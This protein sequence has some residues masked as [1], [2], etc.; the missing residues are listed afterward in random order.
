MLLIKELID[1][2]KVLFYRAYDE[3][4]MVKFW[5]TCVSL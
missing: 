1:V 5:G 4:C 3:I 2:A